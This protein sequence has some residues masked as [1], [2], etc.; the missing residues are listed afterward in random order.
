M[1]K[2]GARERFE[3]IR[4]DCFLLPLTHINAG[5][6]GSSDNCKFAVAVLHG[7]SSSTF[8]ERHKKGQPLSLL[9]QKATAPFLQTFNNLINERFCLH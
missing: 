3:I 5:A 8:T 2:T 9:I 4:R 7:T 6:M 1:V